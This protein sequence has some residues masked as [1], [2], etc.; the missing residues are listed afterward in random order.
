MSA[1][2][3][4]AGLSVT[5]FPLRDQ[6][7]D[8]IVPVPLHFDRLRWR[9]FNQSLLLAHHWRNEIGTLKLPSPPLAAN[10]LRRTRHTRPQNRGQIM[11]RP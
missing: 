11:R 9:G 7:Y 5:H 3:V 8:L 4:L 1:G 6:T 10:L 2:K